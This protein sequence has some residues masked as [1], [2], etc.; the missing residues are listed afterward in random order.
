MARAQPDRRA[1]LT[2][3]AFEVF[4]DRGY[5]NSSV[6]DIVAAAGLGHGSFYNYFTNK[7]EILDATIDLGMDERAPELS[8]PEHLAD[9]LDEFLDGV[10]APLRALHS[11]S[12]NENKLVSLVVFDAGAIDEQLTQ[13]VVEIFESFAAA[14]ARQIDHGV[15]VGYL[16]PDLD[17]QVLGEMFICMSLVMLLSAQ[18]G[19][20]LPGGPDHVIAQVKEVMRAG[21]GRRPEPTTPV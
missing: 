13:R 9:S 4:T 17:T 5:R 18:G 10:T 1:Q 14:V 3:A 2:R 6:A 21:L 16:R 11:L 19:A 15:A 20:P 8:P 12:V 7:R